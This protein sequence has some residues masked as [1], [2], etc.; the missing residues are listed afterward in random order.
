MAKLGH[1]GEHLGRPRPAEPWRGDRSRG[2]DAADRI[3]RTRSVE[4]RRERHTSTAP[5]TS[6]YA[7][8]GF[9][10]VVQDNMYG[11]AIVWVRLS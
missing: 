5:P 9:T 3:L 6:E 7:R 10:A 11:S 4:L 1:A 2:P 8:A